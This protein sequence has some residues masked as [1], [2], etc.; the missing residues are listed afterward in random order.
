MILFFI[1]PILGALRN[2]SKY[3]YFNL[4]LFLRTPFLYF[5][6]YLFF[7]TNNFWKILIYERWFFFMY[8]TIVSIYKK[9]YYF[10]REKYIRK[11]KF[12]S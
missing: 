10:K 6:L 3:R 2:Y 1:T 9:D 11:Y 8:K 4:L 7:Q 5:F 12:Y